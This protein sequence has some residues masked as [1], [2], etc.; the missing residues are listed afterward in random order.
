L[1]RTSELIEFFTNRKW[2]LKKN[3]NK[4]VFQEEEEEKGF[5][6]EKKND[7]EICTQEERQTD[8]RWRG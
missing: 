7:D 1:K 8:L 2:I 3:K 6:V 4:F 5:S